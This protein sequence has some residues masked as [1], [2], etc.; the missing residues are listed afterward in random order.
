MGLQVGVPLRV[1]ADD[2]TVLVKP[3]VAKTQLGAD[4]AAAASAPVGAGGRQP[5]EGEST[6]TIAPVGAIDGGATEGR[7]QPAQTRKP[8]YRRFHGS[9][10]LD[11]LRTSRDAARVA[12]EVSQHLTKLVGAQV[13]VTLEIQATLPDG[14]TDKT[15][16][17]VT[18]NCR[19]LR[20]E[21][22]GFEE[23]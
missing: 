11:A 1:I 8:V 10:Q 5:T 23:E 15:V 12:D 16:R 3:D 9:V 20:F 21:T 2:K 17:D 6:A 22:F 4:A 18:E 7:G 19:T 14:A 13:E